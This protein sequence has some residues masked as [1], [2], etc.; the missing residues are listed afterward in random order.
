MGQLRNL[1]EDRIKKFKKETGIGVDVTI[2]FRD[3]RE[4]CLYNIFLDADEGMCVSDTCTD[5]D[6]PEILDEM[7]SHLVKSVKEQRETMRLRD[8]GR[9][10]RFTDYSP[11]DPFEERQIASQPVEVRSTVT[12]PRIRVAEWNGEIRHTGDTVQVVAY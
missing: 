1:F 7:F 2:R 4:G 8:I 3:F 10:I 5:E 9:S 6:M 12:G 11:V